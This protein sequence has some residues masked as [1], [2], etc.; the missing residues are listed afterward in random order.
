MPS[1][2]STENLVQKAMSDN[3]E[4][5][6]V[7]TIAHRL[8]TVMNSDRVLV[9]EAGRIVVSYSEFNHNHSLGKRTKVM[10]TRQ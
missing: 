9:L 3:F 8:Q 6:T 7:L 1:S 5:C 4:D 2:Y 10:K